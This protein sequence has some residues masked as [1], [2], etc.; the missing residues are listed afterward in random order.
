MNRGYASSAF[1]HA[2]R[3]RG[4]RLCIPPKNWKA[5]RGRPVVARKDGYRLR[6]KVERSFAW[7]SNFRR[8]LICWESLFGMYRSFFTFAALQTCLRRL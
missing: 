4:I 7:S 3:G 5:K 2:L 8:L 6:Y 1:H